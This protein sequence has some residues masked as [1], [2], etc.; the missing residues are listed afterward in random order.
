M[1]MNFRILFAVILLALVGCGGGAEKCECD[2]NTS[3][4]PLTI[5]CGEAQCVNGNGWR[6][7]PGGTVAVAPDACGTTGPVN[8]CTPTTCAAVGATC[9]TISDGCG[10]TLSCGTCEQGQACSS[11]NVCESVCAQLQCGAGLR[12]DAAQGQCV[13][14]PCTAAGAVCGTVD[15]VVCGT[16]PGTSTCAATRKACIEQTATLPLS[17]YTTSSV[18]VGDRLYAAGPDAKG[19]TTSTLVEVTLST[20][21]VRTIAEGIT[22]RSPLAHNG[23]HLF[24]TDAQGLRRLPVGGSAIDTLPGLTGSCAALLASA[25]QVHCGTGGDAKYGVSYYGIK[26]VP[27]GGGT[28]T[29]T[30]QNL[31][32]PRMSLISTLLFYVGTTDNYY[33]FGN[34]GVTDVSDGFQQWLVSGGALDAYFILTDADAYYFVRKDSA[35]RT[36]VRTPYAAAT[37]VDLVT[38]DGFDM[39]TTVSTG[40]D[41]WTVAKIDGALG[42]HRIPVANPAAREAWLSA[43]DLGEGAWGPDALFRTES[44][45][46]FITGTQ[47]RRAVPPLAQ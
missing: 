44:G 5:A 6:C 13:P 31:N 17:E 38:A 47:V 41:I 22:L 3:G 45:W 33:S 43:A 42:L 40:T 9:G 7:Y 34:L 21:A 32:Y 35:G 37:S 12:C 25:T 28:A 29:W 8:T 46:T 27:S 36:L 18:A 16:C 2:F 23:A 1:A 26:T 19:S 4:G 15:G 24:W 39:S 11:T 30:V 20:G 10:G 14:D